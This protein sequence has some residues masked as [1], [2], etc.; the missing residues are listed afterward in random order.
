MKK[1][2]TYYLSMVDVPKIPGD[3]KRQEN[4]LSIKD[5]FKMFLYIGKF[6]LKDPEGVEEFQKS[7]KKSY[8]CTSTSGVLQSMIIFQKVFWRI[9]ELAPMENLKPVPWCKRSCLSSI[10]CPTI[11]YL[12]RVSHLEIHTISVRKILKCFTFGT[13]SYRNL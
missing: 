13:I 2:F 5:L 8:V 11:N 6:T 7:S 3:W 1:T 10:C 4:I 9:L 12:Q